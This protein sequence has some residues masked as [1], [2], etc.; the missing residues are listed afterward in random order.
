M[1]VG[2]QFNFIQP[3]S[4]NQ[5]NSTLTDKAQEAIKREIKTNDEINSEQQQ[6][7]QKTINGLRMLKCL[8]FFRAATIHDYK[9]IP[10][11]HQGSSIFCQGL[12]HGVTCREFL[13]DGSGA[14]RK[15]DE[16]RLL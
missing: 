6:N 1:L 14:T 5:T 10:Y 7:T 4:H 12:A 16:S 8:R 2:I 3:Y 13:V 9:S 11:I 15:I